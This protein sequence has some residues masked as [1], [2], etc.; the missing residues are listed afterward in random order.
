[1]HVCSAGEQGNLFHHAGVT[2]FMAC[3]ARRFGAGLWLQKGSLHKMAQGALKFANGRAK[4]GGCLYVAGDLLLRGNLSCVDSQAG[5]A[6]GAVVWG[7][8]RQLGAH[9]EFANC[10]SQRDAGGLLVSWA[11][12]SMIFVLFFCCLVDCVTRACPCFVRLLL[13]EL[14]AS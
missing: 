3:H 13:P 6:G 5:R 12:W 4:E 7:H 2:S 11:F 14:V 10:K 9:V 1:M 8:L